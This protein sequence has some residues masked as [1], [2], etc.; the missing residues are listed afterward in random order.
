MINKKQEY[1]DQDRIDM[2]L[3]LGQ[4]YPRPQGNLDEINVHFFWRSLYK[5]LAFLYTQSQKKHTM[6]SLT[7]P[8]THGQCHIWSQEFETVRKNPHSSK[9]KTQLSTVCF[10]GD[11]V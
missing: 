3:G 9:K 2:T 6:N 4:C 11:W 5:Y 7:S 8:V 10:F 1:Q